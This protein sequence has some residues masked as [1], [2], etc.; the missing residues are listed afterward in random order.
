MREIRMISRKL[1]CFLVIQGTLLASSCSSHK[2]EV[3]SPFASAPAEVQED[4]SISE[5]THSLVKLF[6]SYDLAD[7]Q[8]KSEL[9]PILKRLASLRAR[10]WIDLVNSAR[11]SSLEVQRATPKSIPADVQQHLESYASRLVGTLRWISHSSAEEAYQFEADGKEYQLF[12]L[13]LPERSQ[14]DSGDAVAVNGVFQLGS[15]L[16][17]EGL[18]I[19][20]K[21]D[22]NLKQKTQNAAQVR[23][24]KLAV[25]QVSLKGQSHADLPSRAGS[26]SVVEEA[27]RFLNEISYGNL[28]IS[29]SESDVLGPFSLSQSEAQCKSKYA[30]FH[31]SARAAAQAKG[32]DL[33]GYDVIA[34]LWPFSGK[35]GFPARATLKGK[36]IW[37]NGSEY[38]DRATFLHELGHILGLEHSNLLSCVGSV[39]LLK[40]NRVPAGCEFQEYG[41]TADAMGAFVAGHYNAAQKDKLGWLRPDSQPALA[42][43]KSSG[44]YHLSAFP[45]ISGIPNA[46]KIPR[47]SGG[48]IFV[49]YRRPGGADAH[50]SSLPGMTSG[51]LLHLSS[52][53]YSRGG[54]LLLNLAPL[55]N[56]NGVGY[57]LDASIRA[58]Q[59]F[60]DLSSSLR[61][62]LDSMNEQSAQ[63]TV[64]LP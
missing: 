4:Q 52:Q 18:E 45:L 36:D 51:V 38:F 43:V 34:V 55:T 41:D 63:I 46:L 1:A 62:R 28:Q 60:E 24:L 54:P 42:L 37:I 53:P 20:Q 2:N 56:L 61:I 5:V 32:R 22:S 44:T 29:L 30:S 23:R 26:V 9:A 16:L 15:T 8:R 57:A 25:I 27:A 21:A 47:R 11:E 58:G 13:H 14:L 3:S 7:S 33:S 10:L 17:A 6:R 64:T 49:E 59:E 50:L 48:N 39:P 40:G 19:S 12:W 35:C 31:R